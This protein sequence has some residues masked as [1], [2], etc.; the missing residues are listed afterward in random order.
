MPWSLM[1]LVGM[2][3]PN[4]LEVMGARYGS[5]RVQP[6]PDQRDVARMFVQAKGPRSTQFDGDRHPNRPGLP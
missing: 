1:I 3:S 2:G 5:Q 6:S 4:R